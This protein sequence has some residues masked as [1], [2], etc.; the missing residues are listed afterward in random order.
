MTPLAPLTAVLVH[1]YPNNL[2][3]LAN[4][5]HLILFL[6]LLLLL[7]NPLFLLSPALFYT[8]H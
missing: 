1:L 8:Q 4:I 3:T 5:E 6:L 2:K 7:I